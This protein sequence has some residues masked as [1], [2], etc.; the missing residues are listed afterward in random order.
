QAAEKSSKPLAGARGSETG[1]RIWKDHGAA[2]ARKRIRRDFFSQPASLATRGRLLQF[3]PCSNLPDFH[4][5]VSPISIDLLVQIHRHADVVGYHAHLL[6][7]MPRPCGIADIDEAVL[8]H[9]LFE[10]R[11][12]SGGHMAKSGRRREGAPV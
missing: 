1:S 8:F 12:G 9:E 10:D 3:A 11:A 5:F 6:P 2:T 7:H 4:N